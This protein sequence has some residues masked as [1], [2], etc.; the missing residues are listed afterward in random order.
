MVK[1]RLHKMLA[2]KKMMV[3]GVVAILSLSW[4]SVVVSADVPHRFLRKSDKP[5]ETPLYKSRL[6]QTLF[7][8]NVSKSS[9]AVSK[10]KKP[11]LPHPVQPSKP[12]S[13]TCFFSSVYYGC[14]RPTP[15]SREDP[16]CSH[17]TSKA[18][19]KCHIVTGR[20]CVP[21]YPP[22][23]S[24]RQC[25]IVTGR[26]CVVPPVPTSKADPRC[27][28]IVTGRMCVYHVPTSDDSP[29]SCRPCAS[30][31]SPSICLG[32]EPPTQSYKS[33]PP[34]SLPG[35][36]WTWK[37]GINCTHEPT[38]DGRS[39]G[40]TVYPGCVKPPTFLHKPSICIACGTYK[41]CYIAAGH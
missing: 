37:W 5:L 33:C 16:D 26:S 39:C 30:T 32:C 21:P 38:M 22:T 11:L 7:G 14:V 24:V 34:T 20:I 10:V 41:A 4:V 28:Y 35:C 12:S 8:T 6:Y 27:S 25:S 1:N 19:P 2:R 18:D 15:T 23:Q 29:T 40:P 9:Y 17:P 13:P 31:P 3:L 36:G